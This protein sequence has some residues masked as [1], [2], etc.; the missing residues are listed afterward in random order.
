MPYRRADGTVIALCLQAGDT[1]QG[2][3]FATRTLRGFDL[4][5]WNGEGGKF[6]LIGPEGQPGLAAIARA[7]AQGVAL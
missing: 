4:I 7:A 1:P 6:V 3:A 2:E 5:S